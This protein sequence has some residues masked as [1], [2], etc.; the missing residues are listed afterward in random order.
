MMKRYAD[1]GT[2]DYS[3]DTLGRFKLFEKREINEEMHDKHE[4]D[5]K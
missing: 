4:G 3:E 5:K 2:E 1:Q